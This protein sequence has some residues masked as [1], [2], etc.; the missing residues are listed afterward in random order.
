MEIINVEEFRKQIKAFIEAN[1][2]LAADIIIVL[3]A[4]VL[5][6]KDIQTQDPN[7]QVQETQKFL[8]LVPF[9]SISTKVIPGQG[10]VRIIAVNRNLVDVLK[11]SFEEMEFL[12]DGMVP[13]EALDQTLWGINSLNIETSKTIVGQFDSLK[14]ASFDFERSE[15]KIAPK[16][17][18]QKDTKGKIPR[19]YFMLGV[20]VLLLVILI[21]IIV[22]RI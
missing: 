4:D 7:I 15:N 18:L 11:A 6:E 19:V 16:A 13:Y 17:D 21:L 12:V 14:E 10:G 22:V 8:D 5:F 9:D 3:S 2:V 1:R 20:F